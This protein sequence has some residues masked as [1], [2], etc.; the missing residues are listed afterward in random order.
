MIF[1]WKII[2]S[3]PYFRQKRNQHRSLLSKR[4]SHGITI[5]E[6]VYHYYVDFILLDLCHPARYSE[7]IFGSAPEALG[8]TTGLNEPRS[9]G[10]SGLPLD[11]GTLESTD[12]SCERKE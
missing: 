7:M 8:K 5:D 10:L 2:S 3:I 12:P 4:G 11:P 9:Q 6:G 1:E